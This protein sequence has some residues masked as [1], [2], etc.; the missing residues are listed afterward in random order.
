MQN[1][2]QAI[3]LNH[4]LAMGMLCGVQLRQKAL[5]ALALSRYTRQR[6]DELLQ[7]YVQLQKPD[8]G[9]RSAGGRR[10][11]AATPGVAAAHPLPGAGPITALATD[12]ILGDAHR[13]AT[14]NQVGELHRDDPVRAQQWKAA[15]ARRT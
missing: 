12:V 2:L 4:A 15:A 13:F 10:S 7:L 8:Q 9:A 5:Q 14:G 3:A 1:T 6:R 11:Q